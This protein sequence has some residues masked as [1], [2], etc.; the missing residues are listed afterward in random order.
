VQGP[1][2]IS[3][4]RCGIVTKCAALVQ[5]QIQVHVHVQP[6]RP[7]AAEITHLGEDIFGGGVSRLGRLSFTFSVC[8][9][10]VLGA[11]EAKVDSAGN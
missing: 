1:R 8:T 11:I 7:F 10:D 5:V 4:L 3:P 6:W 2:L 9:V